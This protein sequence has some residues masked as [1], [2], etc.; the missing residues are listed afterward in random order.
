[1]GEIAQVR[2]MTQIAKDAG[3]GREAL[4]KVRPDASPRFDTVARVSKT[5]GVKLVAQRVVV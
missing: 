2:G 5:L 1:M 4:Y 3:I